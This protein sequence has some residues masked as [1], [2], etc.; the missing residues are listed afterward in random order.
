MKK[1][2][3]KQYI[4]ISI[5]ILAIISIPL[6]INGYIL[7]TSS[8]YIIERSDA[9]N[10]GAECILVLGAGLKPD[11]TPNH[12]LQDRLDEGIALYIEGVAPK[13]LLSGDNGQEEY[14]EVNAMKEYVLAAGVP[15]EDIFMDH[16]GFSTYESMYRARDV[17]NVDNV[18]IITQKYHLYR[19]IYNARQLHLNAYGVVSEPRTYF[20][21]EM[22]EVREVLAR[23]KDFVKLLFKPEPSYLGNVIPISGNG[24]ESHD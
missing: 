24:L 9:N 20:G 21:Q 17:F 12:M 13:L 3:K 19:A 16:A 23:N 14:D 2:K 22:R 8:E 15:S 5:V 18:I 10:I 4:A 7:S 11:G 6:I 1:H